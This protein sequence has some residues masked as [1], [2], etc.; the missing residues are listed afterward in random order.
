VPSEGIEILPANPG[1]DPTHPI[2]ICAGT[3]YPT[4]A[5]F[6]VPR[7]PDGLL[8]NARAY[9]ARAGNG[10]A[11]FIGGLVT[12]KSAYAIDNGE[13]HNT[14]LFSTFA[15][16]DTT[17]RPDL[18]VSGTTL[19]LRTVS[20]GG[21]VTVSY[22]LTNGGAAPSPGVVT[23]F[24]LTPTGTTP[25][26]PVNVVPLAAPSASQIFPLDSRVETATLKF[27]EPI[28]PGT[29]TLGPVVS[30]TGG[31]P[32]KSSTL[33]DNRLPREITVKAALGFSTGSGPSRSGP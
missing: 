30:T 12:P 5:L 15:N 11:R 24:R 27:T 23:A 18:R 9:A 25:G 28:K 14:F 1:F 29:Y 13:E 17:G 16:M 7:N 4:V 33:A 21:T 8:E 20:L 3:T 2:V 6:K 32:E 31:L 26:S 10:V 19:S 22:S